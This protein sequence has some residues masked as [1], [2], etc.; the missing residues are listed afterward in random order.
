MEIPVVGKCKV[1]GKV[2][3]LIFREST[4]DLFDGRDV[5]GK[6]NLDCP[7]DKLTALTLSAADS[8]L[9]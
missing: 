1:T 5:S 8:R 3:A 9:D 6:P 2:A 4:C 7:R